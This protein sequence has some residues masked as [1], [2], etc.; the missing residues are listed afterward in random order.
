MPSGEIYQVADTLEKD[1]W[2]AVSIIAGELIEG[3]AVRKTFALPPL[4][5]GTNGRER[6]R[7]GGVTLAALG[8]NV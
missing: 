4:G 2:L 3:Y 8:E 6:L 5:D 1:D 7:S